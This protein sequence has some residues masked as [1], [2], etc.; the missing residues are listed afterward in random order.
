MT[1][2]VKASVKSPLGN[3]KETSDGIT[4]CEGGGAL[5]SRINLALFFFFCFCLGVTT[6]V[7][8]SL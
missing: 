3:G 8:G 5:L 7:F 2:D 4:W 6:L 1:P